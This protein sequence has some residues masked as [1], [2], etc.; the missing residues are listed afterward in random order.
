MKGYLA[1]CP[2]F[3]AL[4]HCLPFLGPSEPSCLS[5]STAHGL[6]SSVAAHSI[7]AAELV[8]PFLRD[9]GDHEPLASLVILPLVSPDQLWK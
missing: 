4:Q 7:C 1:A 9:E 3:L 2:T 5:S 6:F 8:L